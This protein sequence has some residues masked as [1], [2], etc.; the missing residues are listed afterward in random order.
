ML[1]VGADLYGLSRT[2]LQ[3]LERMQGECEV[4]VWAPADG[5][6][7]A[8][9]RNR[10]AT[11]RVVALPVL[12]RQEVMSLRLPLTLLTLL[13]TT[14]RLWRWAK[15]QRG[16]IALVHALGAPSIGGLVVAR[17]ARCRLVWSVHEVFG[18]RAERLLFAALLRRA[19]A[20]VACSRYVAEQFS[21]GDFRVVHSG[22]DV[23]EDVLS[24]AARPSQ[25]AFGG[26]GRE[27]IVCVGRLNRW[28]GQDVLLHAVAALPEALR[29]RTR[30][31]LVGSVFEGDPQVAVELAQL[32]DRL[33]LR[34]SVELLGERPDAQALM[35]AATVVVVPS[36]KPEPFGKV[37]VEAMALGRA[38]VATRP[39]GPA[40]VVTDGVDGLLVPVDDVLALARALEHLL[41]SPEERHRLGRQ[42]SATARRFTGRSAANQYR[43]LYQEVL[44]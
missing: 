10:G 30:V 5:P 4:E 11:T 6:L 21:S 7:L 28:K 12:R 26:Q 37:V 1:V 40:E 36:R 9:A 17:A 35:A 23:D 42:A 44:A 33:G 19:H 15:S 41:T 27:V 39:G 2:T 29:G 43:A 38:V 22:A 8:A 20:R 14:A 24:A 34:E 3:V 32:R 13:L 16:R 25:A 31:Q 18:S